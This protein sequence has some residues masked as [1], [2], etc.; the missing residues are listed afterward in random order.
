MQELEKPKF[1]R[2]HATSAEQNARLIR[3]RV[4][5][6]RN[7]IFGV[8]ILSPLSLDV[9]LIDICTGRIDFYVKFEEM[10]GINLTPS[11]KRSV[12]SNFSLNFMNFMKMMKRLY[13]FD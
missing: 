4:I 8:S 2:I 13:R 11:E 1:G 6:S 10:H 7:K 12:H 3:H 5:L 9:L